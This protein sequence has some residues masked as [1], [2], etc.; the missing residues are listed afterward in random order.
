MK[1]FT[2][3]IICIMLLLTG[4]ASKIQAKELAVAEYPEQSE[5]YQIYD[6]ETDPTGNADYVKKL[7]A[8]LL[9]D[10]KDNVVFSPANIY[11][12][13]AM[14]AE[15][16]EGDSQK[17][18]LDLLGKDEIQFIRNNSNILW[19]KM[20]MDRGDCVSVLANSMWIDERYENKFNEKTL[21]ILKNNYFASVYNG[22]FDNAQFTRAIR[23]WINEQTKGMLKEQAGE[24]EIDSQ[25]AMMLVS[26][27]YYKAYW[28]D[29]FSK[30]N[31][32]TD[33][34][35]TPDG[36]VNAEFMNARLTDTV[37]YTDKFTAV[38]KDL[39]GAFSTKMTFILPGEKYTVN[40]ILNDPKTLD[41]IVD[42][43]TVEQK[44][45]Y[46]NASV[47]KF[48][49]SFKTELTESLKKLGITDVF[50][51][52]KADFSPLSPKGLFVSAADHA[53]TVKID[54]EG[55]EGAAFTDF[56]LQDSIMLP[57]E[58]I[59]FVLDRPFIFVVSGEDNLPRFVGIVNNP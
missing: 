34:F 41:F 57:T 43:K 25:T 11:F 1:I 16:T 6:R 45:A 22:D 37:Y 55:V 18:I 44:E 40:D 54:E 47:P 10:A 53:S 20:Y 48:D 9:A 30:D 12:A 56:S 19:Q 7:A 24:L 23:D 50:E 46:I 52:G 28:Q 3:L 39:A 17:Q 59:D 2:A 5:L 32:K 51:E 38:G 27:L 35:H 14:L 21:N 4:C 8:V 13:L 31:T 26:T 58:E 33:V 42:E 15:C 49:V 29:K 36:D